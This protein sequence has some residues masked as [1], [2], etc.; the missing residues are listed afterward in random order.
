MRP[1][2]SAFIVLLAVPGAPLAAHADCALFSPDGPACATPKAKMQADF[3]K[4]ATAQ[5]QAQKT[6][7]EA[8]RAMATPSVPTDCKMIKRV[9]P[10]FV[11]KM[12]VQTPDPNVKLPI[13]SVSVPSC[14]KSVPSSGK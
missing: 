6:P 13:Q 11:S 9:D 3:A 2:T 8:Q 5:E 7:A 1:F 12:P 14:G 10:Q 4:L